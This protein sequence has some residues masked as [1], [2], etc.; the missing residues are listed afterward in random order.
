MKFQFIK[1]KKFSGIRLWHESSFSFHLFIFVFFVF[2]HLACSIQDKTYIVTGHNESVSEAAGDL[3]RYLLATY[4][5]QKF[6]VVS[7]PVSDRR[8][9][10]LEIVKDAEWENI[11]AYKIS[12]EENQLIIKGKTPRAIA[13]GVFGLLKHLGWNFYLSFQVP[14]DNPVPLDFLSVNLGNEP[15]K[16]RRILFN[17]H[18][19]ISGCT[20][21]NYEQ[22][23]QWIDN[24]LKIG[25]NT[26]M[27]HAYGNNPM[28]SFTFN[29]LD[30]ELGYLTTTQRG[31]D[32]GAQ[33]VNDVRLLHGGNIF[34]H[35]E[36]GS[37]A[38]KVPVE[39]KVQSATEM[40]QQ[41]F[42]H[43]SRKNMDICFALDVD[44]WIANPQNIITTLPDDALLEILGYQTVNPDHVEGRKYYTAQLNKLFLDYPEINILA[45]WMRNPRQGP[46]LGSTWLLHNSNTLP[47]SW[48][49]EYFKIL[50]NHPE[51]K[52][53][54]PYPGLFAISKIINVYREILDEINPDVELMLGSWR[55]GYPKL[56]KYFIPEFCG[57]IPLNDNTLD[58]TD[59]IDELS[60]VGEN[61]SIYPIV[62]AHHDDHRYLGR[63]YIPYTNFNSLLDGINSKGYGIIHWT[64]HPLD[65][66]FS[67]HENQ[68]WKDTEKIG[69]ASCRER[70]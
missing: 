12:G 3:A 10:L 9:I 36:F 59:V 2:G 26:V 11:E 25:F 66:F 47:E 49:Q 56:A 65:L 30:K 13:Y 42:R 70:V 19:F 4:P 60:K 24:G 17:W 54:R 51:L 16:E 6:E 37:E 8:N 28:H 68:V 61:R 45:A 34:T 64:T 46:G 43:A 38:A 63:P 53:E 57:F 21:W 32:W 22:W 7:Q 62:W 44:T 15:L 48:Q 39:E 23:E 50:E 55:N 40:M 5:R 1:I 18:N 67:N 27:V 14:P 41:V 58:S 35:Y 31:R 52:D 20:G 33:H 29:G 69:R